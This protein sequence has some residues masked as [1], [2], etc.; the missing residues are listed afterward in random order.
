MSGAIDEERFAASL[1]SESGGIHDAARVGS[2]VGD[3]LELAASVVALVVATPV[4]EETALEIEVLRIGCAIGR[5]L[6]VANFFGADGIGGVPAAA[7]VEFAITLVD[8]VAECAV[9]GADGRGING[10]PPVASYDGVAGCLGF[11]FTT[12][13][14]NAVPG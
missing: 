2:T 11:T 7:I 3:G 5:R 8:A 14:A 13:A 10:G 1:A 4:A 12:V 9:A 6:L